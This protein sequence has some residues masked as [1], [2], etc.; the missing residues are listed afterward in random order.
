MGGCWGWYGEPLLLVKFEGIYHFCERPWCT[1]VSSE[2]AEHVLDHDPAFAIHVETGCRPSVAPPNDAGESLQL[3][4]LQVA[5]M[6]FRPLLRWDFKQRKV[7]QV[8]KVAQGVDGKV[9]SDRTASGGIHLLWASSGFPRHSVCP[10][11]SLQAVLPQLFE[12]VLL[13]EEALQG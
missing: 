6:H 12:Q 8:R 9:D 3:R 7:A 11:A 1:R 5:A 2:I 10:P 4:E 13:G